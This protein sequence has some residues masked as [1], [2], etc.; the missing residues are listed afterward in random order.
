MVEDSQ[1]NSKRA[2]AEF[3]N[4]LVAVAE[5][6]V[7]T[8]Y[9]LVLVG[10]EPVVV[11]IHYLAISLSSWKIM[12]SSVFDAFIYVKEVDYIILQDLSLF[13]FPEIGRE[14]ANGVVSA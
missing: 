2:L 7:V 9:V 12:V 10:V 3:L 5:M 1:H 14:Q 4:N 13:N 11:F 8:M 6:F